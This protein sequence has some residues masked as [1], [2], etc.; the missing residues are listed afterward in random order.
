MFFVYVLY[1]SSL[2]KFYVGE[3]L[4]LKERIREHN[5]GKYD[6]SFTKR[7]DDWELFYSINC[8]NRS[9]ARKIEKHIKNMKSKVYLHNLKDFPEISFKLVEKYK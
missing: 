9:L 2:D 7:T 5:E 1:S 8:E 3:T 4:D 6:S